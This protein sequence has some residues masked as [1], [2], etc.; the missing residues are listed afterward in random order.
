M[1]IGFSDSF[2]RFPEVY[3]PAGYIPDPYEVLRSALPR[4]TS[5]HVYYRFFSTRNI[6]FISAEITDRL[7]GVHPEG[8][9]IIV[10]VDQIISVMDSVYANNHRDPDVMTMITIT[11]IVDYISLDYGIEKY[12]DSLNNWI[13]KY[14]PESG[15]VA[16]PKIKL[17]EK[18]PVTMVFNY[19]Y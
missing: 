14:I 2:D 10:P 1:S 5:Q 8:K 7:K 15:M 11:Y 13:I 3:K 17:R 6:A 9:N 12:N 4:P 19:N 16:Y 18:R